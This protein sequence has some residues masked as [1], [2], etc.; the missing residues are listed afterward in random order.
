MPA[1]PTEHRTNRPLRRLP[2][3][4]RARAW[5]LAL[6]L[7]VLGAG[8]ESAYAQLTIEPTTWNV[9]GLDSNRVNDGPNV[10]PIG[11]RVCNTGG[12]MLDN[13][14]ATFYWDSSNAYINLTEGNTLSVRTL[15]AGAC[16]DFYFNVT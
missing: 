13:V 10:F 4:P 8:A 14:L 3:A 2:R 15:A 9:I 6:A 12:T 16:V 7:T 5:M 1:P 11:A